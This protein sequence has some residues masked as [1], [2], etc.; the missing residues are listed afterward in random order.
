MPY[1]GLGMTNAAC[2]RAEFPGTQELHPSILKKK[3][4]RIVFEDLMI[5]MGAT[6]LR[7]QLCQ[8]PAACNCCMMPNAP[9][10]PACFMPPKQV[11]V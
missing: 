7:I 9:V 8:F 11:K 4:V 1:T 2:V 6:R 5:S 3:L 10:H